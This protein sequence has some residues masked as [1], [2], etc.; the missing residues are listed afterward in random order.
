M[1]L[2]GKKS[3]HLLEVDL[4]SHLIPNIDDGS[5]SM[6]QSINMLERL[7]EIGFKKVI[8]TPHIHPRY[9]N[10]PHVIMSG[11]EA[12]QAEVVSRGIQVEIEA[13]AEYYVDESFYT[14]IREGDRILSFGDK[15]VLVESSF[16]NKPIF[17]E[18][19]MFDLLAKG[20]RPVLAHPERYQFLEGSIRWLEELKEMGVMFQITLGSIGGYYGEKPLRIGKQLIAKEMVDFLGSDLHRQNHLPYLEKGLKSKEIQRLITKDLLRNKDLL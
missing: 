3:I 8:T 19:V 18:T 4:H 14:K 11:L 1:S 7:M 15:F 2:F 9:P 10:T 20:F 17:F 5:Q 13:A 6:E 12:L 16:V